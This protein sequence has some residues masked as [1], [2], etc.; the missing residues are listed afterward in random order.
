MLPLVNPRALR[1]G[2]TIGVVSPSFGALGMFPHRWERG[3]AYLEGLGF[4]VVAAPNALGV[5][6]YVSG[7]PQERVDD[8]HAMFRDPDVAAVIAGIGGDHACQLLPLLDW[9]LLRAQPKI[10]MGMSDITVLNV[11]LHVATGLV[12]FNGPT[13]AFQLAEYPRVYDYTERYLLAALQ[14]AEPVGALEPAS[15]WTDELL[16]WADRADLTR[17]RQMT[18]S[19]GWTW[20]KPGQARGRLLGGCLE[21][22]QHLRATP[23]WPSPAHF[24][25]AILFL[26]T[27]EECPD[28]ST[29]DALLMDYEN[30]DVLPRIA[31]LLLANPYGYDNTARAQLRDV[32]LARTDAYSFPIVSDMDFGHTQPTV[33][34]PLGCL[35]EIDT[36]ARRVAIVEAAV[37]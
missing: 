32:V 34:L 6:G 12:T 22:L 23:W 19:V 13:V 31:G 30:M 24:D 11:A 9:E 18:P 33:T 3:R 36:P 7:T 16:N 10:F 25:G 1:R 37:A 29:V 20:L 8:I 14:R 5:A 2:D 4:N 27:S 21:S 26:E 28:P 17:P 35:A 15:A